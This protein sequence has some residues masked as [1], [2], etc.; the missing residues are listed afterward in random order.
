MNLECK[1]VTILCVYSRH[2][3]A[4]TPISRIPFTL[5]I[6]F[7]SAQRGLEYR[8]Q[9]H[10]KDVGQSVT[11]N[12]S[13]QDTGRMIWRPKTPVYSVTR[14]SQDYWFGGIFRFQRL[15]NKSKIWSENELL[16]WW[17]RAS[18]MDGSLHLFDVVGQEFIQSHSMFIFHPDRPFR[19]E[20]VHPD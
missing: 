19:R 7:V 4:R 14:R 20:L 8:P 2:G 6:R 1:S 16:C 18:Q 17:A 10:S 3:T 9:M 13:F 11:L 15:Q 12:S 5:R